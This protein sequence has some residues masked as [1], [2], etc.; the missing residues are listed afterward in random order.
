LPLGLKA[1]T[2]RVTIVLSDPVDVASATDTGNYRIK[3]WSLKRSANY[4]SKHYDEHDLAI[5]SASV[6]EDGRTIELIVPDVA[7]TWGMEIRY[8]LKGANGESAAGVIHNT[9]HKLGK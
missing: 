7:P 1:A 3:V 5:E 6:S 9:I 8:A 4:G 2:R